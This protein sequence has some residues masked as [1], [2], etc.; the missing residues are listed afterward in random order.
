MFAF[1]TPKFWVDRDRRQ[2]EERFER[3]WEW[4]AGELLRGATI[5][6]VLKH[7]DAAKQFE[8]EDDFDAGVRAAVKSWEQRVRF[9]S[10]WI[11][12]TS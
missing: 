2:L 10:A 12:K 4:A 7:P 11:E 3:G 8:C 5:A 6:E 1:L 9:A